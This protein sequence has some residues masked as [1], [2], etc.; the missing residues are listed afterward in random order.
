MKSVTVEPISYMAT[1]GC[2]FYQSFDSDKTFLVEIANDNPFEMFCHQSQTDQ[3]I[4][5]QGISYLFYI[6]NFKVK[7]VT[8]DASSPVAIIIPPLVI[9][10]SIN[11]SGR[12]ASVVN[13]M[14][15][16]TDPGPDDYSPIETLPPD[17][18]IQYD[19]LVNRLRLKHKQG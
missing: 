6:E 9:H 10:G 11:V 8:M 13:A 7:Y 3:L 4:P 2:K 12:P 14:I 1:S 19:Q 5:V 15:R 16:H 17:Q 18:Q